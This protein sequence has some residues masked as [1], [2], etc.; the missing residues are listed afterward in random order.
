M[1]IRWF[2][3]LVLLGGFAFAQSQQPIPSAGE[4][5][6]R[7]QT[8]TGSNQPQ[9]PTE[10]RGTE[11]EPLVVRNIRSKEESAADTA[12]HLQKAATDRW[13]LIL[14]AAAVA[15]AL[16][17]ALIFVVMLRTS[18]QQLRAYLFVEFSPRQPFFDPLQGVQI[19][20]RIVN[21]GQTP[22]YRV[23]QV[24]S[25]NVL[26]FPL[27][28]DPSHPTNAQIEDQQSFHTIGPTGH[29]DI[30]AQ[31][32]RPLTTAESDG[33]LEDAARIYV[34]GEIRYSDA[35]TWWR[36]RRQPRYSRFRYMIPVNPNLSMQGLMVAPEGNRAN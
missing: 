11:K 10:T 31:L 13:T 21:R 4:P 15:G 5:G 17:Q 20:L 9:A 8:Q 19:P 16:I 22:A 3:A 28:S 14:S 24:I 30:F 33:L 36:Y 27:V 18:R 1:L 7:P 29:I 26:P 12:D 32:E 35:F 25:C 23:S 2:L 6:K 34:W